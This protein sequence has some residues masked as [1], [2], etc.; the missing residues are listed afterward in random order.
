MLNQKAPYGLM[1]PCSTIGQFRSVWHCLLVSHGHKIQYDQLH[2]L[3]I[4]ST[5]GHRDH[6]ISGRWLNWEHFQCTDIVNMRISHRRNTHRCRTRNRG[7][8]RDFSVAICCD[9]Q[10]VSS[11]STVN[12]GMRIHGQSDT[13]RTGDK[14]GIELSRSLDCTAIFEI[15]LNGHEIIGA[16]VTIVP[17]KM[18]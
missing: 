6:V 16:S 1:G 10:F 3:I 2:W 4:L 18:R 9:V 12:F 13:G 7:L 8:L 14:R 5:C 17:A 11:I 15:W